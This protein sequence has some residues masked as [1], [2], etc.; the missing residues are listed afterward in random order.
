MSSKNN[1]KQNY[2]KRAFVIL[3]AAGVF[4]AGAAIY[5]IGYSAGVAS[6]TYVASETDD[7]LD[8]IEYEEP[9]PRKPIKISGTGQ[10]ATKPVNLVAGLAVVEMQHTGSSNFAISVLDEIGD[11]VE[12]L[13]NEIGSFNGS[14]AFQVPAEGEYVLD[15]S[16]DGPWKITIEQ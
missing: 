13:V 15:V 11:S 12:L 6:N 4:I 3:I 1:S 10:Q 5:Q 2:N 9:E 14:K 7:Y 8:E 16:A